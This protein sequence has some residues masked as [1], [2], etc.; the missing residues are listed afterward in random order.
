[1]GRW[2]VT[3]KVANINAYSRDHFSS[4]FVSGPGVYP[5]NALDQSGESVQH[6][7]Q[8]TI[9]DLFSYLSQ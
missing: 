4:V 9:D 1:M 5:A 2:E 7:C 8:M 3:E 6:H